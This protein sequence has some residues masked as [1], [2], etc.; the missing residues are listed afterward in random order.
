MA[1]PVTLGMGP[2]F[3]SQGV[4]L[5]KRA[6]RGTTVAPRRCASPRRMANASTLYRSF[7]NGAQIVAERVK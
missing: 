4:S 6:T 7:V 1:L 3:L 5:S 2:H